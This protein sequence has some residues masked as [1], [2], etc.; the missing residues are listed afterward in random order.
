MVCIHRYVQLVDI[1]EYPS[2]KYTGKNRSQRT[3]LINQCPGSRRQFMEARA[4]Q[5]ESHTPETN[6][7]K[8]Q[9]ANFSYICSI[10]RLYQNQEQSNE[11]RTRILPYMYHTFQWWYKRKVP[12]KRARIQCK[13]NLQFQPMSLQVHSRAPLASPLPRFGS[14]QRMDITHKICY[15]IGNLHIYE[16]GGI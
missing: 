4:V 2:D 13:Y 1:I 7:D 11:K 10:Y 3:G 5:Q 6:E 12:H 9:R 14:W 15:C 16:S 8:K